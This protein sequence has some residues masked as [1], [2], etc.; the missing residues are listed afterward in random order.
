ME[1]ERNGVGVGTWGEGLEGGGS[2]RID[3]NAVLLDTLSL[4]EASTFLP[5]LNGILELEALLEPQTIVPAPPDLVIFIRP[6]RTGG[7]R[8]D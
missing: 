6:P 7:A 5:G 3:V 8:G 2:F 4:L 1:I